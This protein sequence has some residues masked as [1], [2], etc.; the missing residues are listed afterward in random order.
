MYWCDLQNPAGPKC[1]EGN[2]SKF[3]VN[4]TKTACGETL[5]CGTTKYAKCEP[6]NGTCIPCSLGEPGCMVEAN[7]KIDCKKATGVNGTYRAIEISNDFIRGEFDFTFR[8]DAVDLMYHPAGDASDG[9]KWE[10][11]TVSME[12]V[13]GGAMI[14]FKV[15]K[16][17]GSEVGADLKAAGFEPKVGDYMKGLY[18]TKVGQEQLTAFM[19]L[20]L[21]L[22][23][24]SDTD[25]ASSFDD[26]MSK[27][28]FNMVACKDTTVCDFGSAS[29]AAFTQE[30]PLVLFQ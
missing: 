25:A 2:T 3:H 9:P 24:T 14:G 27:L 15:T 29:V 17:S 7:C 19:Y 30:V 20:A 26:G 21:S 10:L 11:E 1:V 8:S 22:P 6:T 23:S 28:E 18:A 4:V 5:D 16:Q 12:G 13:N